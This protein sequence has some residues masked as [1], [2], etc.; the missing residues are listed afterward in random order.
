MNLRQL[1]LDT[2]ASFANANQAFTSGHVTTRLRQQDPTLVFSARTVGQILTDS[3]AQGLL[4]PFPA[5]GTIVTAMRVTTGL[6]GRTPPGINVQV[7]AGDQIEADTCLF[8]VDIPVP[9]VVAPVPV[10]VATPAPAPV[11]Q[12]TVGP[13]PL[14]YAYVLNDGRAYIPAA[15]LQAAGI[16][17]AASVTT[18]LPGTGSSQIRVANATPAPGTYKVQVSGRVA[19]PVGTQ[20]TGQEFPLNIGAGEVTFDLV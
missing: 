5:T 9:P 19:F 6:L 1:V 15:A 3:F 12:P 18:P 2:A 17:Q 10:Q 13:A 8:E 20:Y 14:Y 11:T 7:Y 16:T 4:A